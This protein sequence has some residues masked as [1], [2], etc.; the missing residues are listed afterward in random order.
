MEKKNK[1]S[2]YKCNLVG[3]LITSLTT[4]TFRAW[5]NVIAIPTMIFLFVEKSGLLNWLPLFNEVKLSIPTRIQIEPN[6][7]MN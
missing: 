2:R 7:P 6:A 4:L 5:K 3:N 1:S